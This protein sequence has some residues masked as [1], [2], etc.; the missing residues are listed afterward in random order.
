MTIFQAFFLG[1][2]QGL[3]EFLPVS[4]SG[5]LVIIQHLFK[6]SSPSAVFDI[7]IHSATA[8]AVV[9]VVFGKLIKLKLRQIKLIIIASFP[10]AIIGLSLNS[11]I[12]QLFSS[13]K[14]VGFALLI[15]GGLLFSTKHLQGSSLKAK[16]NFKNT[17]LIGLAQVLA[18]IPGISRSGSTIVAGLHAGLSPATVFNFSFLLS[19]P[20]IF[21]A[22]LLQLN[23]LLSFPLSQLPNLL[24]GFITAFFSGLIALRILKKLI[25]NSKFYYFGYYCFLLGLTILYL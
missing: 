21:G 22:Q 24:V 10:T 14:L 18:I 20:A 25:I 9:T 23:K 7:F 11:Y 12:N 1:L 3:T 17:F 13:L 16:L 15:T 6:L 4:S 2:V 8:L 19:L 5:H